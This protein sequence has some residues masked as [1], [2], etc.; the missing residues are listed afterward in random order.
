MNQDPGEEQSSAT[1]SLRERIATCLP[2]PWRQDFELETDKAL[3]V[4]RVDTGA[5]GLHVFEIRPQTGDLDGMVTSDNFVYRYRMEDP[6]LDLRGL[7][8]AYRRIFME[9]RKFESSWGPLVPTTAPPRPPPS[10]APQIGSASPHILFLQETALY[11]QIA[12]HIGSKDISEAIRDFV[13]EQIPHGPA[14]VQLYFRNPCVQSCEF[15]TEPPMRPHVTRITEALRLYHDMDL[16]LVGLGIFSSLMDVLGERE[17]HTSLCITGNDWTRHPNMEGIL[18]RME[19]EERISIRL[20]GP[21]ATVCDPELARRIAGIPKLQELRLS[22][23]S[24]DPEQHDRITGTPGAGVQIQQAI[25]N[26]RDNGVQPTVN[27]VLTRNG[28]RELPS[29]VPWLESRGLRLNLLAFVPDVFPDTFM[30]FKGKWDVPSL[31]APYSEI[32]ATLDALDATARSAIDGIH[33]LPLCAVPADLEELARAD[34]QSE[35]AEPELFVAP[36]SEC[37]VQTQCSGVP[38]T[39][40][41]HYGDEGLRPR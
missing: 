2:K 25:K 7:E 18:A 35:E 11:Q 13:G 6:R 8:Q 39:Y 21:H 29:L 14:E 1:E 33:G 4:I 3:V 10:D 12:Q 17:D 5:S 32:H 36:C 24:S 30:G 26:L 22:L 34:G 20:I 16:D 9:L 15:C 31:M 40:V 37:S 38:K 41:D 23:F 27:T 19:R 28:I